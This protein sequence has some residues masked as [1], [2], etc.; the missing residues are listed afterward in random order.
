MVFDCVALD[1][2][3]GRGWVFGGSVILLFMA[4]VGIRHWCSVIEQL[5]TR[6]HNS[7]LHHVVL[8]LGLSSIGACPF[9][10]SSRRRGG[11][12]SSGFGF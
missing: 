9:V 6:G 8:T 11:T 10:H 2:G 5:V 4:W 12:G 7:H 1:D 3:L